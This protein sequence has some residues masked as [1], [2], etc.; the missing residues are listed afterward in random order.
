MDVLDYG[1]DDENGLFKREKSENLM[2]GSQLEVMKAV[3]DRLDKYDEGI[4]KRKEFV[5]QLRTDPDVV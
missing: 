3:F 5:M 2:L 4:L 1:D